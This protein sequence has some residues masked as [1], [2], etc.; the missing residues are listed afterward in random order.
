MRTNE[1]DGGEDPLAAVWLTST[2]KIRRRDRWRTAESEALQPNVIHR[3]DMTVRFPTR[4]YQHP[5]FIWRRI[6]GTSTVVA[7]PVSRL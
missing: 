6:V 2:G 5:R 7:T 4:W 3:V 1:F